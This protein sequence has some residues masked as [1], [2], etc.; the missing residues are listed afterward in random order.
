MRHTPVKA[1]WASYQPPMGCRD[2]FTV[3]LTEPSVEHAAAE[4]GAATTSRCHLP[5]ALQSLHT[6]FE[7]HRYHVECEIA[8]CKCTLGPSS[9][10]WLR[11]C[12]RFMCPVTMLPCDRYP[13][14]AIS[15][16]GHVF[17]DRALRQVMPSTCNV[18]LVDVV[19]L[20][21]AN[22]TAQCFRLF[23]WKLQLLLGNDMSCGDMPTEACN[24]ESRC[25]A[26][27]RRAVRNMQHGISARRPGTAHFFAR[28][29]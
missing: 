14:S 8:D 15:T 24:L 18:R 7:L 5:A 20:M 4:D 23:L 26:G 21:E 19:V 1:T 29:G 11:C 25:D 9:D 6:V 10:L 13:T 17:S 16:C 2:I 22:P 27:A 12:C 28:A 3:H